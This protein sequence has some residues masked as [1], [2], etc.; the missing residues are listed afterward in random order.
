MN[1]VNI[2]RLARRRTVKIVHQCRHASNIENEMIAVFS[3]VILVFRF[4]YLS[5]RQLLPVVRSSRE[6]NN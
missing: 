1:T 6:E 5:L 4:R 3:N 2:Y